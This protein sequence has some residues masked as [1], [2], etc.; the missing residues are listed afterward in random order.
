MKK[1][2]RLAMVL[3]TVAVFGFLGCTA[4]TGNNKSGTTQSGTEGNTGGNENGNN[5]G[6]NNQTQTV[7][8]STALSSLT[9]DEITALEESINTQILSS[10]NGVTGITATI[11]ADKN[12]SLTYG[13]NASVAITPVLTDDGAIKLLET[14]ANKS[15]VIAAKKTELK[16]TA[17]NFTLPNGLAQKLGGNAADLKASIKTVIENI[18]TEKFAYSLG[19]RAIYFKMSDLDSSK[20]PAVTAQTPDAEI[21]PGVKRILRNGRTAIDFTESNAEIKIDFEGKNTSISPSKGYYQGG[22]RFAENANVS[23][24]GTDCLLGC[25]GIDRS[26]FKNNRNTLSIFDILIKPETSVNF[27]KINFSTSDNNL[28]GFKDMITKFSSVLNIAKYGDNDDIIKYDAKEVV[29]ET[30]SKRMFEDNNNL[31]PALD[32]NTDITIDADFASFL[33]SKDVSVKNVIIDNTKAWPDSR[34][35]Q[36]GGKLVNSVVETSMEEVEGLKVKGLVRFEQKSP[37]AFSEDGLT[38]IIL[39]EYN[40]D[41]IYTGGRY[42]IS[43]LGDMQDTI[44]G[45]KIKNKAAYFY[46][47]S[48]KDYLFGN[49]GLAKAANG[50][51]VFIG[52]AYIISEGTHKGKYKSTASNSTEYSNKDIEKAGNGEEYSSGIKLDM[53]TG[54]LSSYP[55][56]RV[57]NIKLTPMQ[58]LLLDDQHIYG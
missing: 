45:D 40:V 26:D 41:T 53:G 29:D 18:P 15:T 51:D 21:I 10:T 6:E 49:V 54:T 25:G 12:L 2:C 19:N 46:L 50:E 13:G 7:N 34:K 36:L 37:K 27:S 55:L 38:K 32:S 4:L 47:S 43:K 30:Q 42:D 39:K 5:T 11:D 16:N 56:S 1:I 33:L 9:A 57:N 58:K 44:T 8:L 48:D 23:L 35:S 31:N 20:L 24:I 22:L 28:Y 17:D 14:Y 52:Q 3:G